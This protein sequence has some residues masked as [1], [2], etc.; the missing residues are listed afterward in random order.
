[1]RSNIEKI[2]QIQKIPGD[3]TLK[4]QIPFKQIYKQVNDFFVERATELYQENIKEHSQIFDLS[5]T[6]SLVEFM[7][8]LF[9]VSGIADKR[10]KEFLISLFK[11]RH[12]KKILLFSRF[13]DMDEQTANYS[14][15]EYKQYIEAYHDC[16]LMTK[17]VSTNKIREG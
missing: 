4:A 3:Q 14:E 7:D 12:N 16:V 8:K 17:R 9:G 1:M 5:L 2:V 13:L 15:L 11:Y 10:Q 6:F